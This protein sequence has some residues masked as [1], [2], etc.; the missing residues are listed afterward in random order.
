MSQDG[1][2]PKTWEDIYPDT[3]RNIVVNEIEDELIALERMQKRDISLTC[4]QKV[5]ESIEGFMLDFKKLHSAFRR[6]VY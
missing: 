5:Y 2:E 1:D 6:V 3:M 4:Y